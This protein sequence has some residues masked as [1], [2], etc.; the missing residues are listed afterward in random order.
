M[1]Q[2]GLI[3]D[4]R[5]DLGPAVVSGESSRI[6][7]LGVDEPTQFRSLRGHRITGPTPGIRD[8]TADPLDRA[9]VNGALVV[10]L[11][12]T[13]ELSVRE[14]PVTGGVRGRIPDQQVPAVGTRGIPVTT[15]PD[16][17]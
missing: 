10:T 2:A 12:M 7:A 15:F 1:S 3:L 11:W 5:P 8:E 14:F 17:P 6:I 13:G 9:E 16:K 4:Y